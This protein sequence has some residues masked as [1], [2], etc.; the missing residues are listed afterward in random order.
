MVSACLADYPPARVELARRNS[1]LGWDYLGAMPAGEFSLDDLARRFGPGEY[2]A[3]VKLPERRRKGIRFNVAAANNAAPAAA[4]ASPAAAASTPSTDALLTALLAKLAAPPPAAA[5]SPLDLNQLIIQQM[6]GQ[7]SLL[8]ALIVKTLD[9]PEGGSKLSELEGMLKL[10]E[11]LGRGRADDD[12][13]GE[14]GGLLELGKT[15]ASA[16]ISSAASAPAA[17]VPAAVSAA[18]RARMFAAQTARRAAAA[19]PGNP[20]AKTLSAESV[21]STQTTTAAAVGDD[22]TAPQTNGRGADTQSAEPMNPIA[23]I[24]RRDRRAIAL[25]TLIDA[26][27]ADTSAESLA[28]IAI[29]TLGAD[30]R[31]FVERTEPGT[32]AAVFVQAFPAIAAKRPFLNDIEK[33]IRS[34][35]AGDAADE[36]DTIDLDNANADD[37]QLEKE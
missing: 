6:Q 30:I 26:A 15:L 31:T 3:A 5:P 21:P 36:S 35:I 18:Q 1:S 7:Q 27:D 29:G 23:L 22:A 2:R 28:D 14:S 37:V 9:R 17:A 33:Q 24:I 16:W 13:G 8:Q 11:R 10:A 19:L 32:F 12:A 20:A 4:A 34:M 25:Q